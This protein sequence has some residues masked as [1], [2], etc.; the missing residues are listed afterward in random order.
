M[1]ESGAVAALPPLQGLGRHIVGHDLMLDTPCG[2]HR[3]IYADWT[4]SG[5]CWW[6]CQRLKPRWLPCSRSAM[7]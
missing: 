1:N 7:A 5:R 3:M 4:A 2:R 6:H